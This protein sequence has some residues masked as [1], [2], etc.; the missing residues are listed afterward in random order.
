MSE[1][2]LKNAI[3]IKQAVLEYIKPTRELINNK[4]EFEKLDGLTKD[5]IVLEANTAYSF[6]SALTISIGIG[7][8]QVQLERQQDAQETAETKVNEEET[9]TENTQSE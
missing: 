5:L 1:Q 8:N 6:I 7:I 3:D 4:E 2:E 9:A